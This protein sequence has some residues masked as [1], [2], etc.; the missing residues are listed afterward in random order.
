MTAAPCW[1]LDG[2]P[3]AA[4]TSYSLYR[5]SRN[6]SNVETTS[7]EVFQCDLR[8]LEGLEGFRALGSHG[9]AYASTRK[10]LVLTLIN[11]ETRAKQADI[12]QTSSQ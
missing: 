4:C 7:E 3:Y 12:V 11:K 8:P 6:P 5:P 1:P 10:L 9:I 2:F